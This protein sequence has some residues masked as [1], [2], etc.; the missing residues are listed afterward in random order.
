MA[1]GGDPL[2]HFGKTKV[3]IAKACDVSG[4]DFWTGFFGVKH[5][6]LTPLTQRAAAAMQAVMRHGVICDGEVSQASLYRNLAAQRRLY[7][8]VL[9]SHD[10]SESFVLILGLL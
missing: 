3:A 1:K 6:S 2:R 5:L 9:L 4:S 7:T 10:R 8:R